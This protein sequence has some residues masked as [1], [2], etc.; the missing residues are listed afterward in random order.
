MVPRKY[1]LTPKKEQFLRD[2]FLKMTDAAIGKRLR[3]PRATVAKWRSRLGLNKRGATPQKHDKSITKTKKA[4]NIKRMT[5]EE[6]KDYF[7]KQLRTR[8]RYRLMKNSMTSEEMQFYEEKYVE[9]FSS[10]DIE[11]IT[12]QEEDDLHELTALQLRVLR[13]Q[14]E[15]FDSR[16]AT[17]QQLVDHSKSIKESTDQIIKL[18]SSL[19]LERRQRLQRQEDSATNFTTL[20]K[21][22]NQQH[23]RMLVGEEATM[24]KFRTEEAVN[25]LVENGLADG[26][27][28]IVL[29]KNF[30]D[31]KLPEDYKP[32]ELKE[33]D[34][35]D[36]KKK[37]A[38]HKARSDS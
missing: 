1:I 21:E 23:T 37:R 28:K 6:K 22:I 9:Y 12:I 11:T 31:G 7:L 14:K 10:P 16:N 15:E 18:K 5:D 32:P 4:V 24:L 35:R 19:D 30:V 27:D 33:R 36:G 20:L 38:S 2:N 29:E 13:L 25:M 34:R 17:G 8:P 26:V 3:V